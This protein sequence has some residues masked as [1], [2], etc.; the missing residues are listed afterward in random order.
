MKRMTKKL[1]NRERRMTEVTKKQR[2][3][4]NDGAKEEQRE[5]LFTDN[6]EIK[7]V[8]DEREAHE[9]EG[10]L[11][12]DSFVCS[13]EDISNLAKDIDNLYAYNAV[14]N[15]VKEKVERMKKKMEKKMS[16]TKFECKDVGIPTYKKDQKRK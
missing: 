10:I 4:E 8:K 12:E 1:R 5:V 7:E 13:N 2:D 14:D 16:F 15:T 3:E 11:L 9:E 6:E